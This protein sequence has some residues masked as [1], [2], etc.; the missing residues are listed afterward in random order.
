MLIKQIIEFELRGVGPQNS[1][2][3]LL[4]HVLKKLRKIAQRLGA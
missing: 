2:I 1:V 4:I 3:H